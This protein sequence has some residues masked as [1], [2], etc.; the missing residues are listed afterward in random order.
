MRKILCV[1]IVIIICLIG[2]EYA[3]AQDTRLALPCATVLAHRQSYR[4]AFYDA[5]FFIDIPHEACK[6][7]SA[8]TVSLVA[9]RTAVPRELAPDPFLEFASNV[10]AYDIVD[11]AG[12][13]RARSIT[14]HIEPRKAEK[15]AAIYFFDKQKNAWQRT[16]SQ[17][18]KD[19][20]YTAVL[21]FSFVQIAVLQEKK[22][23]ERG[24]INATAMPVRAVG[25]A[26]SEGSFLFT[27]NAYAQLPLASIT[28][29]MTVLVFFDHNPGWQKAVKM[30]SEDDAPP[31]KIALGAGDALYV[32]DLFYAT[33]IG[34][35]NNA[36]RALARSTGLSRE[37]F[38]RKMNEK[39]EQLGM[40]HTVFV[41]VTGLDAK[42]RSTVEDILILSRTAFANLNIAKAA[43]MKRYSFSVLGTAR[44]ETVHSTNFLLARGAFSAV[45]KTG[46]INESGY[47]FATRVKNKKQEV[48][49]VVFGASSGEKRE[50][51]TEQLIQFGFRQLA[52]EHHKNVKKI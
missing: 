10:Y 13:D 24:V 12:M 4:A 47:N 43:S 8:V 20:S 50:E 31:A 28:K 34:S 45:G 23:I 14:V 15:T 9:W 19:E 22:W 35:K 33:L 52:A 32:K 2:A 7:A 3:Y 27:K 30:H 49:V 41:D 16:D 29:L 38:V 51:I 48:L 37:E 36:A 46:Y 5:H 21:P 11:S 18:E 40:K 42:N 44:K 1:I 17:R 25:V 6:S 39:A 26:D